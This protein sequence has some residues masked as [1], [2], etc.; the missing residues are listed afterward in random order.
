MLKFV[1]AHFKVK[2][3]NLQK[4]SKQECLLLRKISLRD[5]QKIS[6][7]W[8]PGNALFCGRQFPALLLSL[9]IYC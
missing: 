6:R 3:L 7:T 9:A 5:G 1:L 8:G 2:D 4:F